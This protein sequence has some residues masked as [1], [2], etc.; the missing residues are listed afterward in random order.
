MSLN[1]IFN[2]AHVR[3]AHIA[4]AVHDRKVMGNVGEEAVGV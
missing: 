1:S 3:T 2:A 4:F